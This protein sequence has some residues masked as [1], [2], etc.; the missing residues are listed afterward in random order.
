M[1]EA[2]LKSAKAAKAEVASLATERKNAALLAMADALIAAGAES[3]AAA[4]DEWLRRLTTD[5]L[6]FNAILG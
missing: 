5:E 3:T 1:I 4:L 2:M 6:D